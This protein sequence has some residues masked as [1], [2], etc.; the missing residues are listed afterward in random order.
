[1]KLYEAMF[2][3]DSNR[4]RQDSDKVVE[5]IK[6]VIQKGGGE[7]V[8][9]EKWEERKLA[10][11]I[12]RQR[13]GTYY[14]AH[15]RSDGE[16]IGR[17]ER[18]AQLNETVLR[19]LVLVDED[20]EKMP[21]FAEPVGDSD[22]GGRRSGPPRRSGGPRGSGPARQGGRPDPSGRQPAAKQPAAGAGDAAE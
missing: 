8:N 13:R 6:G 15:F 22:R 14:L 7:P 16:A 12:K 19:V 2:V 9:C 18:A 21:V 1:L 17:I 11:A 10:Y 4:A 20:G 3:M 5:E